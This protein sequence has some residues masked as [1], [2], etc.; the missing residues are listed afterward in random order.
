MVLTNYAH[1]PLLD[2]DPWVGQRSASY[3]FALTNAV[4]GEHLGDIHPMRTARL[5]HDTTRM[6][7]RTLSLD[8]GVADQAAVNPISDR[9]SV[10]M[11]FPNGT[12]YPL[13]RYMFT[14]NTR[15]RF[16]SG[17]LGTPNLN[18]E[19]FLVDQQITAGIDGFGLGVS[20]VIQD[21]LVNLPI[22]YQ[23][24]PTAF[25][26]AEAWGIGQHR[27]SILEALAVSGDY[28]SPW[29][30]NN[31]ILQFIRTFNPADRIPD[32]DFDTGNQVMR[33]GIVE[34]DDLL[35]AP[36]VFIV[37]SNAATDSS[38]EVVGRASVPPTAPHSVVNRG[39]EIPE[40]QDLQLSTEAQAQAV[41]QGLMNRQTIFERV[42]VSTAPDPRFDGYNVVHWQGDLWLDLAWSLNLVEGS[43]MTHIMR[44]AYRG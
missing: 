44:R 28:F 3:R 17:D 40:V 38:A 19:M 31:G 34:N 5:L 41:A 25:Q 35:T 22:I 36:N 1:D 23:L 18:D 39:F 29:F 8:L 43:P 20:Q 12:E 4:T 24:E 10:Y 33:S 27:G 16:T 7:K 42:S 2:L 13:G 32:F 9:V 30:D 37:I 21:T 15:Q 11:V 6:V 14:D 26:C